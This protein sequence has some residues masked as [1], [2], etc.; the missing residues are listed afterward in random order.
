M[1]QFEQYSDEKLI[2]LLKENNPQ[3]FTEIYKR[4]WD[5]LLTVASNKLSDLL[6]AEELVQEIFL[7]IWKRRHDIKLIDRID[8]YLAAALKYKVINYRHKQAISQ[9]YIDYS[10]Q[11][12]PAYYSME[13]YL[14]FDELK[15][16]L[17][18]LV[19]ELPEKC[20]LVYKMS[21]EEGL[22]QKE[23]AERLVIAEKTVEAHLTRALK[24]I[25]AGINYLIS[26]FC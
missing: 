7:D 8:R 1:S 26:L 17:E 2:A 11:Q 19:T 24:K 6:I 20:Q 5:K 12:D 21:R 14:Q 4:N 18:R 15:S 23:I 22:S 10:K 9:K 3:A 13:D 25:R 16:K